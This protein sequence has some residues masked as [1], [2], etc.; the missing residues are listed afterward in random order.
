MPDTHDLHVLISYKQLSELLDAVSEIP[1]LRLELKRN[2][3][4][5]TALKGLYSDVLS[6]MKELIK[7]L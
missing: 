2:N 7:L 6:R 5:L 1:K 3:A 4:E